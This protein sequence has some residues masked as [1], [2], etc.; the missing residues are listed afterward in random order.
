M[1]STAD[2]LPIYTQL[3]SPALYPDHFTREEA[4]EKQGVIVLT[5]V[6]I[7][8]VPRG[9]YGR[10][11]HCAKPHDDGYSVAIVW[12]RAPDRPHK[13]DHAPDANTTPPADPIIDWFAKSEYE[14]YL[15]E[16]TTKS[17]G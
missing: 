15:I 17:K 11:V 4:A 10:V 7:F 16:I 2:P 5:T 14:R 3:S 1:S 8:E 9:T 13:H 6:P 12:Q